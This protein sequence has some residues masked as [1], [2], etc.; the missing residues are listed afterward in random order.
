V[1]KQWICFVKIKVLGA[2]LCMEHTDAYLNLILT[3]NAIMTIM[4]IDD[5]SQKDLEWIHMHKTAALLKVSVASGAI[6][7]GASAE[8]IINVMLYRVM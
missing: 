5:T 4:Y 8:G 1:D 7:A 2:M 6:L 3:Y